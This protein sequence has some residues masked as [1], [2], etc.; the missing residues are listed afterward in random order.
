MW[1][2][3]LRGKP[4]AQ[5]QT[6]VGVPLALLQDKETT[7]LHNA[8]IVSEFLPVSIGFVSLARTISRR[9]IAKVL[10][11]SIGTDGCWRRPASRILSW[12]LCHRWYS[13]P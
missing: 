12:R 11:L 3:T 1:R 4:S 13:C 6:S 5:W 7:L 2:W 9:C 10:D 8:R